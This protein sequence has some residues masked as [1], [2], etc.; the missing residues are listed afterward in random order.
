[1]HSFIDLFMIMPAMAIII[2][3]AMNFLLMYLFLFRFKINFM[4]IKAIIYL[5]RLARD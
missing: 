2:I 3:R 1:M 5:I 4:K